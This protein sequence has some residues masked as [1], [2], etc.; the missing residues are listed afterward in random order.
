MPEPA[1]SE[2]PRYRLFCATWSNFHENAGFPNLPH[3]QNGAHEFSRV[4]RLIDVLE[5]EAVHLYDRDGVACITAVDDFLALPGDAVIL[6]FASHGM[7]PGGSNQLFRLATGDTREAT[8]LTRAFP[9][10]EVIDRLSRS[11]ASRKLLVV[12]ACYSGNAASSMLLFS[13]DN[14]SAPDG[15]CLLASSSPFESSLAPEGDLLTTF[16]AS[17]T[18]L[19][20]AG[21]RDDGPT[22]SVRILFEQLRTDAEERQ[23]PRPWMVASGSAADS[24]V[25][26]N[27]ALG[28]AGTDVAQR[29]ENTARYDHRAE[30]LYVDDE[31]DNRET[32]AAELEAGGHHVTVADS[33]LQGMRALASAHFDIVVVDLLLVGDVPATDFIQAC[34][35]EAEDSQIF[36][37]SRRS[38]GTPDTWSQLDAIFPFPNPISAFLWKPDYVKSIAAHADLIRETR[39]AILSHVDGLEDAVPLV[40]GRMIKRRPDLIDQSERL[41]LQV[42]ICVERLVTK[43]FGPQN[44]AGVFVERM[45]LEPIDSG[46]SSSSVFRLVPAICGVDAE[47][48]TPLILKLGPRSEIE[49]E[50]SRFDRYVQVGVPLDLRTEKVEAAL[51]G[52]IGGLIYSFRGSHDNTVHELGQLD[53]MEISEGLDVVFDASQGKKWYASTAVDVAVRPLEHFEGLGYPVAR[54]QRATSALQRAMTGLAP[55]GG[56]ARPGG[57]DTIKDMYEAPVMGVRHRSTLVHGDLNL[58][59]IVRFGEARFALID[60]RTV[61]I[62]PRLVDFATLEV[63]CWLLAR[64]P[65]LPRARLFDDARAAVGHEF[66]D[67]GGG[68]D[69]VDWLAPYRLLAMKCRA[70]ARENFHDATLA[71]Y[72]SLLWLAAVRRSELKSGA[73]SA[74]ER[75]ALRVLPPA[76]ALAAQ[77]MLQSRPS[78]RNDE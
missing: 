65:D 60:Y 74:Q 15:L 17:L 73:A 53:V 75:R 5:D 67:V 9:M 12:D 8:D 11:P 6:Y 38:K 14:W 39:R 71:E 7:P 29:S 31:S 54:F 37:V 36:V 25:F 61:G 2:P 66:A 22:L 13:G 20:R 10:V 58:G 40:A 55:A 1:R 42:R 76:V 69:V 78:D 70:L 48:V 3:T 44:T 34:A 28:A 47:S 72:G 30:I 50:L 26:R 41:Q 43:W 49:E 35:S 52:M 32:F 46:R 63:A 4:L 62:G 18:T 27:P 16:T 68:G 23:I 56:N 45:A 33:P 59:N 51:A 77:H 24:I 64:A 57:V 19:L 21:T